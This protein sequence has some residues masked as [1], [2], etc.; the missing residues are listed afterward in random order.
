[1]IIIV[2]KLSVLIFVFI[3][4]VSVLAFNVRVLAKQDTNR[5]WKQLSDSIY[6][7][8]NSIVKTKHD[9]SAEFKILSSENNKLYS[10]NNGFAYYQIIKYEADC[11]SETLYL[12]NVKSFDK[13]G[14][15]L[16]N[17][18]NSSVV[19]PLYSGVFN[20]EIYYGELCKYKTDKE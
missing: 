5:A 18:F 4:F 2:K 19:Y 15:I 8:E 9:I 7:D 16:S 12:V 20:G 14:K 10:N 6:I 1:M 11:T 3:L 17:E 13:F